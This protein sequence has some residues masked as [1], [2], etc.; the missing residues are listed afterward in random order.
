MPAT[1]W[2][3]MEP[4]SLWYHSIGQYL[5]DPGW[6]DFKIDA[7]CHCCGNTTAVFRPGGKRKPV[8][9]RCHTIA[10][11]HPMASK[12][13]IGASLDQRHG[14]L[15]SP[16]YCALLA[17]IDAVLPSVDLIDSKRLRFEHWLRQILT[18]PPAPPF[19]LIRFAAKPVLVARGLRLSHSLE[20]IYLCSDTV[21]QINAKVLAGAA[22]LLERERIPP[23]VWRQALR[24]HAIAQQLAAAPEQFSAW[25]AA[26]VQLMTAQNQY[27][28]LRNLAPYDGIAPVPFGSHDYDVL[29]WLQ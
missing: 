17:D 26:C 4:L 11:K 24:N 16:S 22:V 3:S 23:R 29:S 14:A 9:V 7:E 25:R 10:K 5:A 27:P 28:S 19:L 21:I 20:N 8:C 13:G 18:E 2:I 1:A 6:L 12:P 15:I